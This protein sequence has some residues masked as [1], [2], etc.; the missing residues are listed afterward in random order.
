MAHEATQYVYIPS[1]DRDGKRARLGLTTD[2]NSRKGLTS[3]VQMQ[4]ADQDGLGFSFVMFR[5][6]NKPVLTTPSVRG[7]QKTIDAHHA[8]AFTP[9]MIDALKA[10]AIAFY[11]AKA[12][13]VDDEDDDGCDDCGALD[14]RNCTCEDQPDTDSLEDRGVALGS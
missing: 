1:L 3:S 12:A 9:A 11:A 6:F 2:T 10:E 14:F 8:L 7:T 5:D 4:F 13:D